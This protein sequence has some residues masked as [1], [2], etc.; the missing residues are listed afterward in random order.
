MDT[1]RIS[2]P[3][4]E[5]MLNSRPIHLQTTPLL[6]GTDNHQFYDQHNDSTPPGSPL[7][8]SSSSSSSS[9]N[10]SMWNR[11]SRSISL[12]DSY[13]PP[14]T[15]KPCM[16]PPERYSPP[17]IVPSVPPSH[18]GSAHQRSSQP[19]I[20]STV[21]PSYSYHHQRSSAKIDSN[22]KQQ[23]TSSSSAS[24]VHRN[25]HHLHHR[26]AVSTSHLFT[27]SNTP[28]HHHRSPDLSFMTTPNRKYLCTECTKSFSRPSSLR[29]HMFSHTGE[30][31]FACPHPGCDRTFSVQSNMRR[32]IRVHYSASPA[33]L[34][35][36]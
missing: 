27:L 20:T 26:R 15:T 2:L 34:Y 19:T 25:Q 24:M 29:T 10:S 36:T 33:T 18:E 14:S 30:K 13:P 5:T 1:G 16:G 31:P 35:P 3:S 32:H 22:H 11:H 4:I 9:L 21:L 12:D 8:L 17:R 28:T 6:S 7:L 23:Q